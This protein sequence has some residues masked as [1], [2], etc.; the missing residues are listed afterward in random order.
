MTK[1]HPTPD[2]GGMERGNL[3][4]ALAAGGHERFRAR[5]IFQW[6]YRRGV[7]DAAE[8]T[9]LPQA[10][11]GWLGSAFP[12]AAPSLVARERSSDGTSAFA[13]QDPEGD[14]LLLDPVT[15]APVKKGTEPMKLDVLKA[16]IRAALA[17]PGVADE[18]TTPTG[19]D[20]R[21]VVK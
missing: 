9:D 1:I 5:Q 15:H 11:R 12:A 3:E 14:V 13:V 4:E 10:L 7:S 19:N 20:P 2:L 17:P 16:K 6:L 8:M 21:K 18:P